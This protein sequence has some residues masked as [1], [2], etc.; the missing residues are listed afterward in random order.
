[1]KFFWLIA[2]LTAIM[3]GAGMLNALYTVGCFR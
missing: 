2:V 1:M 3:V